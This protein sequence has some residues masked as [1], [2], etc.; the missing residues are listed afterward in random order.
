MDCWI[1]QL[2]LRR[3]LELLNSAQKFIRINTSRAAH[4]EQF[5]WSLLTHCSLWTLGTFCPL[6]EPKAWE[7]VIQKPPSAHGKF[8]LFCA[9]CCTHWWTLYMQFA[10]TVL[11]HNAHT[12]SGKSAHTQSGQSAH[13]WISRVLI[14]CLS[15]LCSFTPEFANFIFPYKGRKKGKGVNKSASSLLHSPCTVYTLNHRCWLR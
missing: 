12:R 3:H 13:T 1:R 6:H 2:G 8:S 11:E 4:S 5:V 14:H 9:H 7:V 10:H 15:I